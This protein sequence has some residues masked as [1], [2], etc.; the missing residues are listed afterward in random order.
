M[1]TLLLIASLAFTGV[2]ST[3]STTVYKCANGTTKVY[4]ISKSC[5]A[6]KRCSHEVK[7]MTIDEARKEGLRLC[8][9]ED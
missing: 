2:M 9:Y 7:T 4:H 5:S 8:G 1:K 3:N 6:L